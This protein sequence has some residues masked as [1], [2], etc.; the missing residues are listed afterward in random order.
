MLALS[1]AAE[2]LHM[3]HSFG[4]RSIFDSYSHTFVHRI[5]SAVF[6]ASGRQVL[7]VYQII[8]TEE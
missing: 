8:A 7:L 2:D 6:L 3:R 5:R 1:E 4:S